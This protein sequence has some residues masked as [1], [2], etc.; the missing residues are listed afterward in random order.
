MENAAEALKMAAAVLIFVLALSISINAF[1]EA[2]IASRTI[3]DY[4]DR[5]YDYTYVDDNR[6]ANGYVVTQRIVSLESIVPT[7]YKAYKENYK[8]VFDENTFEGG[9]YR[10]KDATGTPVEVYS[11]DLQNEILGNDTQKEQFIMAILYGNRGFENQSDFETINNRFVKNLGIY[12]N[13]KGIYDKINNIKL[14]E[15]IGVY[16]QEET[17][18][19]NED[20][21]LEAP[22][23]NADVPDANKTLKRVITYS[24]AE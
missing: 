15:S 22:T 7:I 21:S 20:G 18:T 1:G 12:L 16:Y 24:R 13:S 8:I 6:D 3:L 2:R 14:K 19:I 5:E 10:R 9:L 4:K 11:I 23:E 17:P